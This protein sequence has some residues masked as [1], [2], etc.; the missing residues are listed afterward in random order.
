MYHGIDSTKTQ[1]MNCKIAFST[2]I[3]HG[4][5]QSLMDVISTDDAA[6]ALGM[7]TSVGNSA[8]KYGGTI[9]DV[10]LHILGSI[11]II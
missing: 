2:L 8:D 5:I 11:Y 7:I 10:L 4:N 6:I 9:T 3:C 1:A